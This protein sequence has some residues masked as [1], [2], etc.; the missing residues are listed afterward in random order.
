MACVWRNTQI[1][2]EGSLRYLYFVRMR[3]R[4]CR[5]LSLLPCPLCIR[6]RQCAE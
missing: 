2:I 5:D 1:A 3:C 6:V 4:S